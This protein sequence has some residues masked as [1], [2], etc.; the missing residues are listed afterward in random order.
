VTTIVQAFGVEGS[1]GKAKV[2]IE[3]LAIMLFV[4]LVVVRLAL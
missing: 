2:R 1:R 3:R 4:L